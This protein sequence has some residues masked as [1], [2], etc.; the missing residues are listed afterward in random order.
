MFI[1]K[2]IFIISAIALGIVLIFLGVYNFA[3]KTD[4]SRSYKVPT[5]TNNFASNSNTAPQKEEKPKSGD[6]IHPV[7]DEPVDIV[8]APL[9]GNLPAAVIR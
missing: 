6:K 8:T 3:F 4:P 7:L 9:I 2:K 5:P 1:S